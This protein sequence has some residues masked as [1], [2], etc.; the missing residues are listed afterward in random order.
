M[1][2]AA[3]EDDCKAGRAIFYIRDSRSIPY[4]LGQPLPL[5]AKIKQDA[6][7]S[8]GDVIRAGTVIE[9]IQCEIDERGKIL[10]GFRYAGRE[11]ICTLDEVEMRDKANE[12]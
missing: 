10:I 1:Q 8:P 3:D 4:D 11:G 12:F 9:I 5:S 6:H 7:V 2:R